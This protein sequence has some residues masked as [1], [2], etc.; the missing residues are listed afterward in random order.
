[1]DFAQYWQYTDAVTKALFFALIA[2]SLASWGVGIL[3]IWQSR[4]LASSIA[5]DLTQAIAGQKAQLVSLSPDNRKSVTEQYL[6]QQLNRYRYDSE[7][8]LSV[9]GT[10][11]AVA[12]FIGLFGTVWGIFHALHSIGQ[13]GQA[14]LG[15]VAG[16]VGE[17]LIMTGLGLSVAI[18]AVI[19][20]NI[21]V[22]SNRKALHIANDTAH[23]LLANS[24]LGNANLSDSVTFDN[25][26]PNA[27][28]THAGKGV[29]TTSLPLSAN[30]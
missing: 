3:R 2:L 10:T 11:A 14:G 5:H 24:V 27:L 1:M 29:S 23:S 16:P 6:L 30:S 28:P 12:P 17:A 8:G 21:A 9:L 19:M 22:R 25:K 26:T 15:Q 4:K 13:S 18:P 7:K 20:Y